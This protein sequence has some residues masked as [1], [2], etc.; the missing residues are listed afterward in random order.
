MKSINKF[1]QLTDYLKKYN[2][3]SKPN[4]SLTGGL[5]YSEKTE[6]SDIYSPIGEFVLNYNTNNIT[7]SSKLQFSDTDIY[8]QSCSMYKYD[9]IYYESLDIT[10]EMLTDYIW[11]ISDDNSVVSCKLDLYNK[12]VEIWAKP[13]EN[14]ESKIMIS[15]KIHIYAR[16]SGMQSSLNVYV[17]PRIDHIKIYDTY[18]TPYTE[19][20]E[21]SYG[22]CDP[23]INLECK[24]F[25]E[26]NVDITQYINNYVS[27]WTITDESSTK[28][29]IYEDKYISGDYIYSGISPTVKNSKNQD[30][31]YE[32]CK[33]SEVIKKIGSDISKT[34]NKFQGLI[35]SSETNYYP[36]IQLTVIRKFGNKEIKY[37]S[38]SS[39]VK[40]IRKI[41]IK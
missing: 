11:V 3:L 5:I 33:I 24:F 40:I 34:G 15:T 4:I 35:N 23:Y 16:Y 12:K 17:F 29:L 30:Y 1:K 18:H 39:D 32:K 8:I 14:S 2:T 10:P 7:R 26:S 9:N 36:S 37:P 19:I 13:M 21:N 6:D 38:D 25:N 20:S 22:I 27:Y 31:G 28:D 41:N